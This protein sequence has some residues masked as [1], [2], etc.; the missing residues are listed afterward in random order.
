MIRSLLRHA[1]RF[2]TRGAGGRAIRTATSRASL[3][4]VLWL[5]L[6]SVAVPDALAQTAPPAALPSQQSDNAVSKPVEVK[7]TADDAAIANRIERILQST[8]WFVSPK[9]AVR[10]GIVFMDG[11]TQTQEHLRWAG[12]LAQNTQGTVAVV[13]R[14][15]VEADVGSTFGRAGDEFA[16]LYRQAL[17]TWPWI[18]LACVIIFVTWLLARLV[19]FVVRRLV[20]RRV[21]SSLLASVVV[22]AFSIPVF[23]LGIYFVLQVAGLTRLAITVLGGTGLFG[24][25]IGFAF[26]DIAENFLASILLS[27]RNPFSTGDLIEVDGNTGIVQNLNVRTTVLLTLA[28]NYVQIPNAI[29]FKSTITNYSASQSRQATFA[30]GIGYDSSTT[31]AQSLIAN[32]LAQHPAVLDTPEPLVLVEELGAATVNL[33][34]FYWFASATY[35][36]AKINSA[37]LRLT[38]DALLSGGIELPDA[39]R[40]VVFPHG[41]PIIRHDDRAATSARPGGLGEAVVDH[42]RSPVSVGE[43]NLRNETIEVSEQSEG[44]APESEENLL[45]R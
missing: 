15:E 29:V 44:K 8:N 45:K 2:A 31:K 23:L 18:L 38:K 36:P 39:A 25:I 5:V 41:V 37:L 10:D 24:I 19:A 16:R 11:K 9:V 21:S 12:T 26:R 42:E 14:I 28:G 27:V 20:A 40:E 33:R 17:Q 34:V 6:L 3:L 22:Q 43:G 7:P 32:V 35:S 30:V 13:N 1:V 4:A